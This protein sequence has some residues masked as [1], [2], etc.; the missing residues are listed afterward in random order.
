V[1]S[2]SEHTRLDGISG[3]RGSDDDKVVSSSSSKTRL[4]PRLV[5]NF[6]SEVLSWFIDDSSEEASSSVSSSSESEESSL[7]PLSL[8]SHSLFLIVEDSAS[9]SS[10]SLPFGCYSLEKIEFTDGESD[11]LDESDRPLW[12]I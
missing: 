12:F 1:P 6:S 7:S 8:E 9:S 11:W 2:R 4:R 10:L 3:V 5:S